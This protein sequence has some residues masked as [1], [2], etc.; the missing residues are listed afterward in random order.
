[1]VVYYVF[2]LVSI[3]R[4]QPLFAIF[5]RPSDI[6]RHRRR[7]RRTASFSFRNK[8]KIHLAH[9]QRAHTH[10]VILMHIYTHNST[11]YLS[12]RISFCAAHTHSTYKN[13]II[14]TIELSNAF[15][16]RFFFLKP[17][18]RLLYFS[19]FILFAIRNN[20]NKCFMGSI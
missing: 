5:S 15:V 19:C 13:H 14:Q 9:T 18:F 3:F 2:V 20:N 17:S 1:M 12:Q 8:Q 16:H 6:D 11:P 4:C 10:W 7:H